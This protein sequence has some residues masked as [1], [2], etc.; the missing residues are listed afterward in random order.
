M[1]ELIFREGK[2]TDKL[3]FIIGH[4]LLPINFIDETYEK[5]EVKSEDSYVSV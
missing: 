1:T 4:N 2:R 5:Y 3:R